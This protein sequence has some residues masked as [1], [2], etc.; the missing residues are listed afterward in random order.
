MKK[1]QQTQEVVLTL[2]TQNQNLL[3]Y[4]WAVAKVSYRMWTAKFLLELSNRL[5][6]L[7]MIAT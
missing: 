7:K 6:V 1:N 2:L 5:K 3:G 4:M